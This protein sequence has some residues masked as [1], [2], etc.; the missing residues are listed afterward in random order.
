MVITPDAA[1]EQRIQRQLELGPYTE[2]AQV[3]ARAL[4]LLEAEAEDR[5]ISRERLLSRL[6]ESIAQG[7]RGEGISGEEL[8]ARFNARKAA[9][10]KSEA[11]SG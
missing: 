5:A 11:T 4:D 8:R 9:F 7:E 3:I 1:T 10:E 2:P 6:D